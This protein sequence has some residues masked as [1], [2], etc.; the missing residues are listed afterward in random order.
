LGLGERVG[1]FGF[2]ASAHIAI[3]VARHWG[4]EPYVF[5]RTSGNR[6]L[7]EELGAAWVGGPGDRPPRLLHR[8]VVFAPAGR[9]VAAALQTLERGGVVS[10]ASIT[11]DPI[12]AIDY[13]LLFEERELRSTTAATREDAAELLRLAGAIPIRARV[14]PFPLVEANRALRL[15][16]E[17]KIRGAAALVMG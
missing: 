7:A 2:G 14:E 8:A 16:K 10:I 5:T 13:R 3:Q 15:L 9:L 17:S 11:M 12:P 4:C 1:L 6:R